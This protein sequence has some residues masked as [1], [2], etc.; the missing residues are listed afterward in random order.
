MGKGSQM[1][2]MVWRRGGFTFVE[3]L[4]AMVVASAVIAAAYQ[5][6]SSTSE[7]MY[8]ADSL[9]GTTDRARFAL[10]RMSRDIQGAGASATH[11]ALSD[12]FIHDEFKNGTFSIR[13][14]YAYDRTEQLAPLQSIYN[15]ATFSDEFIMLGALDYSFDFELTFPFPFGTTAFMPNSRFGALR[16]SQLDPFITGEPDPVLP[17]QIVNALDTNMESRVLR[18]LDRRGYAQFLEIAAFSYD[19][20]AITGGGTFTLTNDGLRPYERVGQE[21][22][23][24]EP[25]GNDDD[26]YPAA[27][28]DAVRYRVCV[29]RLDP[30]NLKLVRER[31]SA[32][33]L[34][35]GTMPPNPQV[36]GS[37]VGAGN[38]IVSQETVVDRVVDF[39][40]WYD[41]L[42]D[43]TTPAPSWNEDWIPPGNG[44]NGH[45]CTYIDATGAPVDPVA[46]PDQTR[47]VHLRLSVRTDQERSDV[48]N[49]GFL[50]VDGRT[51]NVTR[52]GATNSLADIDNPANQIVGGLQTFDIDGDPGTAARVMT[53][54]L[55][56]NLP[57]F[58]NRARIQEDEVGEFGL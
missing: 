9:S 12:K 7:A 47:M 54:Q 57:N 32:A 18:V 19:D 42:T 39:R 51:F 14:I 46:T 13:G 17:T 20:T 53:L 31:L 56:V 11:D 58:A 2:K 40:V 55:D 6:F 16:F 37:Q 15:Q 28:L 45:T 25:G 29:D 52:D 38:F 36:C 23:G 30:Q 27:L 33:T 49:Y 26:G 1:K 35:K 4:V 44:D 3:L 41:C 8:E 34:L 50:G 48:D 43:G 21:P 10:E 5:L 24:L 22:W